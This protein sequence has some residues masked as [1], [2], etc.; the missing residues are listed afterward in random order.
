MLEVYQPYLLE[1]AN[2]IYLPLCLYKVCA[3]Y[4]FNV[5]L[6]NKLH[7]TS[8]PSPFCTFQ[9]AEEAKSPRLLGSSLVKA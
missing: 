6:R 8:S 5:S 7:D 4:I 2:L 1:V 3:L 9:T